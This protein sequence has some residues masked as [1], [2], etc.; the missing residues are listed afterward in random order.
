MEDAQIYTDVIIGL[1]TNLGDR[2]QNLQKAIQLIENQIGFAHNLSSV[3]RTS[4]MDFDGDEFLNM[5]IRCKTVLPAEVILKELLNIEKI[6]GRKSK[7]SDAYENRII[8]LDL[9][10]YG[11]QRLASEQLTVPHPH[12]AKRNFVVYPLLD[13]LDSNYKLPSTNTTLGKLKNRLEEPDR[14]Q[15][16]PNS[17]RNFYLERFS[18]INFLAIEGNIGSGKTS[19][20]K[21]IA[22]DFQAEAIF[23]RFADNPFLPK[24]Y[25]DQERF[26]FPLEMSFLADRYQQLSD[27]LAQGNL[28]YTFK[29]ADYYVVKSLIFSRI[30]LS[31]EEYDLYARLFNMMYKELPKPDLYI[32]LHQSTERLLHNIAKRGRSYESEIKPDYLEKIEGGYASYLKSQ[33]KVRALSISMETV[34]FMKSQQDYL[35]LLDQIISALP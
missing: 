14:E 25:K 22:E 24:F 3:Y 4:A 34:D 5:A 28:F 17:I 11:D 29:V 15:F 19:L 9:L 13:L 32:Y 7:K 31:Q 6:M 30:T 21:K 2:E 33:N 8:D 20:T 18:N 1:G 35:H 23:E 12:I 27:T 26:A 10:L 16:L